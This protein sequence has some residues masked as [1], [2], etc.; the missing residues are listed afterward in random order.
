MLTVRFEF[1]SKGIEAAYEQ[2][3][4]NAEREMTR[5]IRKAAKEIALPIARRAVAGE[6]PGT[7]TA[8][9]TAK[10]A[11]VRQRHPGAGINEYGGTR[12][13]VIVPR[14]GSALSTPA[15]PRAK[16]SGPR[17]YRAKHALQRGVEQARP[18]M[19]KPILDATLDAYRQAGFQVS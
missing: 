5:G 4:R 3:A 19:E 11:Y 8:G 15:G 9:A 2:A 6:L 17:T 12:N 16:V 7:T 14:N 13:D 18:L 1:D 10:G